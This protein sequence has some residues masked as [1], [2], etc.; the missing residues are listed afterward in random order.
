[1]QIKIT[2]KAKAPQHHQ[3]S[4]PLIITDERKGDA[5]SCRNQVQTL[6][7]NWNINKL[8]TKEY[9]MK[10]LNLL[11]I[12]VAMVA[13]LVSAAGA[14]DKVTGDVY[15]GPV[16]K[17][18][19]RGNNLSANQWVVQGGADISYK[20]FTLSY[21]SNFQTHTAG[22]YKSGNA[23]ETDIT[24]NYAFTPVSLL[25]FNVGDTAY[26][27]DQGSNTNELYLKTTVNTLLSPT[28]AIYWD[29]DQAKKAGLFYSLSVG[30]TFELAK[31]LGLNLGALASYNQQNPSANLGSN[32]NN[33]H[34]YEL[35][36]SVDYSLTDSVKI[37]PSF[38]FS[39]SFNSKG[40]EIGIKA[41]SVYGL[42][43]AYIF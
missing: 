43:V 35:S 3:V 31:G 6:V 15:I 8:S 12:T 28:L 20:N 10:K 9:T 7:L 32:Y 23:T 17:Y 41:E 27:F 38:L 16:N 13:T 34:N 30:H 4:A 14:E 37:T 40:R 39:N 24:L 18:V 1:V 2:P 33:L 25:T 36:T 22:P 42:K 11:A 5:K 29:W 26:T 21:W 19:F